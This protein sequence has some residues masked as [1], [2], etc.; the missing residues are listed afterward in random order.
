[1]LSCTVGSRRFPWCLKLFHLSPH[2]TYPRVICLKTQKACYIVDAKKN[3][4][5]FESDD[6]TGL[7]VDSGENLSWEAVRVRHHTNINVS[8]SSELEDQQK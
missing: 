1:M 6:L 7:S 4:V 2:F 3:F 8:F 5:S